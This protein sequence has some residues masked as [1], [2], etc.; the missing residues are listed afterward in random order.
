[1]KRI[2]RGVF[3]A[4]RWWSFGRDLGDSDSGR[5]FANEGFAG[6]EC[7]DD[8]L[9]SEVDD[10]SWDPSADLMDQGHRVACEEHVGAAGEG[11]VAGHVELGFG[12][13]HSGHRIMQCDALVQ[14]SEGAEFDSA[15]QGG[16]YDQETGEWRV[17]INVGIGQRS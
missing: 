16:L 13:T 12:I 15:S 14:G 17:G 10:R 11:A 4:G 7:V 1:M 2:P 6:S 8:C 3:P 5:G 9:D